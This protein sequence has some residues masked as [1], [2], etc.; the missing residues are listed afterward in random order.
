VLDLGAVDPDS[1]D[2]MGRWVVVGMLGWL[3]LAGCERARVARPDA[4]GWVL[5][6]PP[7]VPDAAFPRG[8]RFLT[9]APLAAWSPRATFAT[10][11][12]CEHWKQ[13]ELDRTIDRAHI[14]WGDDAKNDLDVRRAVN[15]RCVPAASVHAAR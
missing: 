3:V 4:A 5:M 2:G 12:A 15:A 11:E 9:R 10:A 7:Q 13:E 8:Q 1:L 14:A 6:H